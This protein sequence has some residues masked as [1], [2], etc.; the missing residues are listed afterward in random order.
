MLKAATHEPV[1]F[2]PGSNERMIIIAEQ[3][4]ETL[5]YDC[6]RRVYRVAATVDIQNCVGMVRGPRG[7]WEIIIGDLSP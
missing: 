2:V 3:D 1:R 4:V 5:V 7:Y 6:W